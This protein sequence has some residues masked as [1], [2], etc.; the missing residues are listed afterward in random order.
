MHDR[1]DSF[2]LKQGLLIALLLFIPIVLL[3]FP[4]RR[5]ATC[6]EEGTELVV[7]DPVLDT[8]VPPIRQLQ[9][10]VRTTL[11]VP[12]V[13]LPPPTPHDPEPL[14]E[15]RR[16]SPEEF[17][18]DLRVSSK[19]HRGP[20]NSPP[21]RGPKQVREGVAGLEPPQL[22]HG[23]QPE[24]PTLARRWSCEGIVVIEA[25]ID[26]DGRV[27][28]ARLLHSPE[29]DCGLGEAALHAVR[30]RRYRPGV[31]EGRTVEVISTIRIRFSS[32]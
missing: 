15:D 32:R 24:Y 20:R 22:I 25:L 19:E 7:F 5:Q 10:L 30:G 18:G 13:I 31:L 23:P 17:A 28:S 3:T 21:R 9:P 26:T 6:R 11:A 27:R 12:N 8:Y 14:V 16:A 29:R 2:E 4:E 1:D